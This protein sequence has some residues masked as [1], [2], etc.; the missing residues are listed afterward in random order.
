M[1]RKLTEEAWILYVKILDVER[2]P[3]FLSKDD[4]RIYRLTDQAYYRYIRRRQALELHFIRELK[5]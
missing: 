3:N 1:L 4:D 5:R 2:K